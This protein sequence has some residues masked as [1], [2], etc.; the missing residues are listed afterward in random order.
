MKIKSLGL[1]LSA[2][3]LSACSLM[4]KPMTMDENI[5]RADSDKQ[6]IEANLSSVNGP[7]TLS[8]A[9]SRSLQYNYDT[10]IARLETT[11]EERRMDLALN[12]MLPQLSASS[13]Y[14]HRSNHNSAESKSQEDNVESLEYSYSEQL[15]HGN[16]NIGFTWNLMDAGISYFQAKQQGYRALI[17]VE[18]RRKAINDLVRKVTNDYWRAKTAQDILPR[19]QPMIDQAETMMD[20][21]KIVMENHM[22]SPTVLMDYQQ[23][24]LQTIRQMQKM[25]VDMITAQIDLASD[26]HADSNSH[27]VLATN[28]EDIH[29][30]DLT[31]KVSELER[32]GLTMRPDIRIESYQQKI[33]RQDIYKEILKIMPGIGAVGNVNFDSNQLLYH[34]IWGEIGTHAAINLINLVNAPKQFAIAHGNIKISEQRRL[35]LGLAIITQINL[36]SAQYEMNLE[37]MKTTSRIHDVGVNMEEVAQ[38]TAD[39]GFESESNRIRHQMIGM[40]TEISYSQSLAL[41]QGNLAD[42]YNSVGI[43]L[44]NPDVNFKNNPKL[45]G[46]IDES[47]HNWQQGV[48]PTMPTDPNQK[49]AK[50]DVIPANQAVTPQEINNVWADRLNNKKVLSNATLYNGYQ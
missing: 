8:H 5:K 28:A 21:S 33:D 29:P 34:N 16:G 18:R 23:S 37:N 39:A 36:A 9:I 26:I 19:L 49:Q 47:I 50:S 11:Q 10:E 48:L 45:D 25:K 41:L 1:V 31:N 44:V 46:I 17:A 35:A 13:G 3:T 38:K 27:Y 20:Q 30:V 2:F 12:G 24:L 6:K 32:I 14:D 40:L 43:D 15:A 4:P 7:L 22:Q 42:I